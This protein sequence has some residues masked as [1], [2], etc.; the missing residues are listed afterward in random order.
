MENLKNSKF[1]QTL[2]R[3]AEENPV[4]VLF[5][6]AAVATAAAKLLE[7]NTQRTYAKAHAKEVAR[8]EFQTYN[9]TR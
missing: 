2:K 4:Y 8:R 3:Q 6:A 1:V 5:A 9:K 7:A